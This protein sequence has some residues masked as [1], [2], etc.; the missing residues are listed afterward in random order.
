MG[1]SFMHGKDVFP[2][3][4]GELEEVENEIFRILESD[5]PLV[6]EITTHL[7]RAGG[8]RLRPAL[9]VLS[10]YFGQADHQKMIALAAA[11]EIVHMAT[12]VHDDVIDEAATRRGWPTVNHRFGE[13]EAI[14][15]GDYL[16]AR[17]FSTVARLGNQQVIDILSQVVYGMSAGEIRQIADAFNLAQTESDYLLRIYRKTALFIAECCELGGV[18]AGA[19]ESTCQ[20]LRNFGYGLGMGF[21]GID[22][23]LD[24]NGS[25]DTLGKPVWNDLKEGVLTLPVLRLLQD[26]QAAPAVRRMIEARDWQSDELE[27]LKDLMTRTGAIQYAYDV[28]RRFIE[29]ARQELMKLPDIWARAALD[30]AADFVLARTF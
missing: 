13:R 15:A 26:K 1:I 3:I 8:K 27:K 24:L 17:A 16:F 7:L 21:Q 10:S 5:D 29:T 4:A 9:V 22:D 25:T 6:E 20:V 11:V 30:R 19:P 14:L 18:I 12:L 28:A 23:I 2:E